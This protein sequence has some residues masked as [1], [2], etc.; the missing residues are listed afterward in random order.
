MYRGSYL[1]L[2]VVA[3]YLDM[4]NVHHNGAS[5]AKQQQPPDLGAAGYSFH[6]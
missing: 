6:A 5:I 2:K 4:R 3:D 1:T